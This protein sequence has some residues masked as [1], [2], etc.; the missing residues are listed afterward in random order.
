MYNHLL[1]ILSLLLFLP[2]IYGY[3]SLAHLA[4]IPLGCFQSKRHVS[5]LVGA[6]VYESGLLLD[7]YNDAELA[8]TKPATKTELLL[9][10]LFHKKNNQITPTVARNHPATYLT[11][12]D[13]AQLVW[14]LE[15]N[16][17]DTTSHVDKL[18]E[19]LAA[20]AQATYPTEYGKASF[21]KH[22][23][24]IISYMQ[25]SQTECQNG[26]YPRFTTQA[27]LSAVFYCKATQLHDIQEYT[28]TL[29]IN[30]DLARESTSN[31]N[32]QAQ[33]HQQEDGQNYSTYYMKALE[34]IAKH[35]YLTPFAPSVPQ[36]YY[37]YQ[38]NKAVPDCFET[39]L[40][41]FCNLLVYNPTKHSFD[42]EQLSGRYRYTS[43]FE[44][45]Y[46][47]TQPAPLYVKTTEAGQAWMNLLSGQ[48]TIEYVSGNYEMRPTV[49]NFIAA[50]N[51]LLGIDAHNTDDLCLTL[52]TEEK[53]IRC[54]E[55]QQQVAAD[56]KGQHQTTATVLEFDVAEPS[57]NYSFSIYLIPFEHIWHAWI[58]IPQRTAQV[59]TCKPSDN[60][61]SSAAI[62]S[63]KSTI[64]YQAFQ[65]LTQYA[66][67]R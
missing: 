50:L 66:T 37:G 23:K 19:K 54:I 44:H 16:T 67:S 18:Y 22:F 59:S 45:Y 32:S 61:S 47:Y 38:Q 30:W 25:G 63:F 10:Y 65:R 1:A 60:N 53:K 62:S 52:S 31:S 43:E 39:V 41:E 7:L 35:T 20:E 11:P 42:I 24:H 34:L 51:H 17:S 26:L 6:L 56:Y 33:S 5:P 2:D 12:H 36:G 29:G 13:I 57:R 64:E 27:L 4:R 49:A 40:R 58:Q 55:K 15:Q 8:G 48:T 9:R 14:F 3:L 28:K 46:R 21:K